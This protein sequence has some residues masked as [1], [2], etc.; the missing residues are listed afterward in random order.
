MAYSHKTEYPQNFIQVVDVNS[1]FQPVFAAGKPIALS[2]VVVMNLTAANQTVIFRA[3]AD[4]PEI[5]RIT[6]AN[7]SAFVLPGWKVNAA[8]LEIGTLT[9]TAGCHATFFYV[10]YNQS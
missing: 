7:G 4:T 5:L 2:H 6:V 9:V 8:G 10:T 3:I 1:T